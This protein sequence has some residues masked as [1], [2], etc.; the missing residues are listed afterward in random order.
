MCGDLY[1]GECKFIFMRSLGKSRWRCKDECTR[2]DSMKN[3]DDDAQTK[4]LLAKLKGMENNNNTTKDQTA[5]LYSTSMTDATRLHRLKYLQ[6]FVCNPK[7]SNKMDSLLGGK[8]NVAHLRQLI[9]FDTSRLQ[10]EYCRNIVVL[11]DA[12]TDMDTGTMSI[13]ME[14]MDD[15]SL[16]DKIDQ[17]MIF[18]IGLLSTIA[19]NG[20]QALSFLHDNGQLHRDIKPAN[21]LLNS[22]GQVKLADFGIAFVAETIESSMRQASSR[23]Q[24]KQRKTAAPSAV[25]FVGTAAYM[26]PE[27]LDNHKFNATGVKGYGPPTDVWAFGLSLLACIVGKCPMPTNAGFFDLV[28]AICE[29]PSPTLDRTLYPSDL[30]DFIDLCLNKNPSKRPTAKD[31]LN[32]AFV[33]NRYLDRVAYLTQRAKESRAGLQKGI[34]ARTIAFRKIC[35]AVLRRHI[36]CTMRM[37]EQKHYHGSSKCETKDG[38]NTDSTVEPSVVGITAPLPRFDYGLVMGLAEQLE[39]SAKSCFI[40]AQEEWEFGSEELRLRLERRRDMDM[41]GEIPR[42]SSME[43]F[44]RMEMNKLPSVKTAGSPIHLKTIGVQKKKC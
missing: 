22:H 37:Y 6:D 19:L 36:S 20:L 28:T 14:L 4:S 2:Q 1:C 16:Q 3:L 25:E 8:Q 5:P 15:G 13:V 41:N 29:E 35:A 18:S 12:F 43:L 17:K 10:R 7:T 44:S 31:L 11:H 24:R 27:R 42:F 40:L 33:K 34:H 23:K 26:S 30:C 32:H 38:D 21:I 39:L 9:K